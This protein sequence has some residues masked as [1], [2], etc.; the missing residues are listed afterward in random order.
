[1]V[2]LW[3][4]YT[5]LKLWQIFKSISMQNFTFFEVS[6]YFSYFYSLLL[7]YSI[8]KGIKLENHRGPFFS[9]AGPTQLC[10]GPI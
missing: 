10:L 4:R 7:I 9:V 8:G 6:K 1:M 2:D 3:S 5:I